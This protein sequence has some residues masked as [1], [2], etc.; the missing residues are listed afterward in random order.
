M[1]A[2]QHKIKYTAFENQK[3]FWAVVDRKWEEEIYQFVNNF[4]Q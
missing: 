2:N 3:T 4:H 1:F